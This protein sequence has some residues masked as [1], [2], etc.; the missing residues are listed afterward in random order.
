MTRLVTYGDGVGDNPKVGVADDVIEDVAVTD[1]VT[2]G[3]GVKDGVTEGVGEKDGVLEQLTA[4]AVDPAAQE[5]GQ[6][7]G[8]QVAE[9]NAPV[10]PLKVPAA[11][12]VGAEEAAGQ[13]P[14]A[15]HSTGTPEM[16]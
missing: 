3:V 11:Q 14:P 16:Q 13:N 6:V 2:E 5:E 12:S 8:V 10:A 4:S 9:L 15:V 1:G 7:Q